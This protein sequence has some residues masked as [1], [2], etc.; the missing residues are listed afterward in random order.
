LKLKTDSNILA[1]STLA[2]L[3]VQYGTDHDGEPM[4]VIIHPHELK[5]KDM[6]FTTFK[7][8][9]EGDEL[10]CMA[11]TRQN[12]VTRIAKVGS[13]VVNSAPFQLEDVIGSYQIFCGGVMMAVKDLMP[14]VVENL[15][16]AL[17]WKPTMGACTFGEQGT[18]LDGTTGHGNLM[19]ASLV[20]SRIRKTNQSST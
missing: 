11:G 13:D 4:Y 17:D 6:S 2:P 5:P 3:G 19:F 16:A 10:V 20:F 12:L 1:A 14:V 18:F 7:D 15:G 8:L 9:Q